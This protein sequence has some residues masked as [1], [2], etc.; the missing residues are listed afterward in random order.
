MKKRVLILTDWTDLE[1]EMFL[2]EISSFNDYDWKIYRIKP[3]GEKDLTG[4][5]R[6]ISFWLPCLLTA[7]RAF[8]SGASVVICWQQVMGF[9]LGWIKTLTFSNRPFLI[10]SGL[11]FRME[12]KNLKASLKY[13]FI[14]KALGSI[15]KVIVYSDSLSAIY[16]SLFGINAEKFLSLPLP[17]VLLPHGYENPCPMRVASGRYIFSGGRSDRDFRTLCEAMKNINYPLKI[18]CGSEDYKNLRSLFDSLDVEFHVNVPFLEFV[19]LIAMSDIVVIPLN[20]PQSMNGQ[21]VMIQAM[22]LAKPVIITQSVGISGY[23]EHG[24][25]ALTVPGRDAFTLGEAIKGALK[26]RKAAKAI[27]FNAYITVKK[28]C[29]PKKF[30]ESVGAI[31][32]EEG[33]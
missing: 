24:V 12:E 21:L 23:V 27:G 26:D 9:F 5:R 16:S 28:R 15:D 14:K 30:M 29:S 1:H 7:L 31:L 13:L 8:F 33:P 20:S 17:V 11:F 25:N 10:T 4:P 19:N 18:A 6:I 2:K 32:S 3:S 22:A